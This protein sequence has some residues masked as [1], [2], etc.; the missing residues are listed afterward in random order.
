MALRCKVGDLAVIVRTGRGTANL[1]GRIVRLVARGPNQPQAPG[2]PYD[3]TA[4]WLY[5]PSLKSAR[6]LVVDYMNDGCLRRLRPDDGEDEVLRLTGKPATQDRIEAP[7]K[8][9]QP[10]ERV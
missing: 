7:R 1:L 10:K 4:T 8:A 5:E 9:M 2:I 3:T 6:G